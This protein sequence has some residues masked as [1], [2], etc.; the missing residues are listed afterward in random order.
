MVE[1]KK[2][3][4]VV[5][6]RVLAESFGQEHRFVY[7]LVL[8]HKNQLER[9]GVLRFENVKP[10]TGRPM[11]IAYLTESQALM[12]LTYTRSR[13]E[14]D[15]LRER[16]ITDF[17][18]MRKALMEVSLNKQNQQWLDFR[19]DGKLQRRQT[20]DVIQRF[21]EY[22]TG[23][24]SKHAQRYYANISTMEN[25]ALFFIGQRFPNLRDAMNGR[26]LSFAK[27]ADIIIEEA[28]SEGLSSRMPYKDI[29][30]LC[31]NRVE[32]F[33]ELIPKTTI[34]MSLESPDE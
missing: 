15:D 19:E 16:L 14:T 13:K 22:A 5:D 12:L 29:F 33:A 34:P 25:R 6:S 2:S 8:S 24:G 20:T 32:R 27:S 9:F 1:I 18:R 30:Q 17:M 4:L 26:Q 7:R 11:K 23:N 21:V 31:K 3:V 10:K 28:I